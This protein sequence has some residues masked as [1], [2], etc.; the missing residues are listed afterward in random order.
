MTSAENNYGF[1]WWSNNNT[2]TTAISGGVIDSDN[3]Y[4]LRFLGKSAVDDKTMGIKLY[5]TG[6]GNTKQRFFT[7]GNT[8]TQKDVLFS[9]PAD[10]ASG[11]TMRLSLCDDP[12]ATYMDNVGLYVANV[13]LTDFDNY[14]HLLYNETGANKTYYLSASMNDPEGNSYTSVTLAPWEGIILIGSGTTRWG[15]FP[16][17]GAVLKSPSGKYIKSASGNLIRYH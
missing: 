13:T 8:N 6:T 16:A 17:E 2:V 12:V 9:N 15:E 11:A 4:L 3:H 1:Y 5:S 7:V 14:L 10:V